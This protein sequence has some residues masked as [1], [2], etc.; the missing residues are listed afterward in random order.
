MTGSRVVALGHFQPETVMT[1]ADLEK[2][3]ETSDEWIRRRVGIETRHI[4]GPAGPFPAVLDRVV[5][6]GQRTEDPVGDPSKV[7][8]V[9]L[10]P[11]GQ[12]LVVVHLPRPRVGGP[13]TMTHERSPM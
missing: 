7:G 13:M 11:S 12:P 5:R 6:L 2:L 9:F 8:A 10:E 1:N 4:A 3:V